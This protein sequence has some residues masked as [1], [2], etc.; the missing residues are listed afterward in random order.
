MK[1]T[2]TKAIAAIKALGLAARYQDREFRV[3]VKESEMREMFPDET[4][5]EILERLELRAYYTDDAQDAYDTA[6]HMLQ[7]WLIARHDF[8]KEA[9]R[10]A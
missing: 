6:R 9:I 3:T 2:A 8:Y 5:S 4:R 1:L 10:N 7:Q